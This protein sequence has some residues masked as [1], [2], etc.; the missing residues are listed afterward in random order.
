M[1]SRI[2][3]A[4]PLRE[5]GCFAAVARHL[6]FSRAAA[7]L[8]IS[9]PAASQAVG[10][11]ERALGLRLFERTSRE[12]RLTAAGAALLPYAEALLDGAGAFTAEAVRLAAQAGPVIRLAYPPLLGELA[13]RVARRLARRTPPIEVE[14]RAAGWAAATAALAA[15][16][17]SVAIV[18]APFPREFTTAARFHVPVDHIAV[19][20]GDP[21]AGSSELRPDRLGRHKILMPGNRPPGGM[22]ARLAV[23]LRGPH[24]YRVV[25]DDIDDYAALLDLVAAGAGLLPTPHLLVRSVRRADVVFV[26]FEAGG[27]RLSYG[28]AWSPERVSPELMALVGAVQEALWTR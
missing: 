13:A 12:V 16:E 11:L 24:Q 10:R 7:E 27:L 6:G 20:A 25:A 23:R 3:P 21:L 19:P 2:D 22:W 5:V 28:V 26:P 18:G 9:Q 17:A 4:P 14:L 15:G 1:V 8:G